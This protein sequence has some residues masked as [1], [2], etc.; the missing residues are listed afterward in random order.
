[1][2]VYEVRI[3]PLHFGKRKRGR[4]DPKTKFF[5]GSTLEEIDEFVPKTL[6]RKQATSKFA[7]I[8]DITGKLGPMLAEAEDWVTPMPDSLRSRWL[9]QFLLWEK[10]RG[11]RFQ[12][13][14]MPE[15]AADSKL[16]L[17]VKVDAANK[18]MVQGCWGGF[19]KKSGNWSCQHLLARV[20]L[21]GKNSTIPKLELQSL[22]NGSNM[23]WLL[24]K[25]L[26]DWVENYIV[27][28]D[29][30]IALCWVSSEKSSLSMFHRNRVIQIRRSSELE[31]M[32]HV[33]SNENLADLGTRPEKVKISDIGPDSEWECGKNWMCEDIKVSID[34]GILTPITKL[35]LS[36]EKDTDVFKEGLLSGD[37]DLFCN[38]V[39]E[40]RVEK[41]IQRFNFSQYLLNPTKYDFKKVVRIYALVISFI[42]KCKQKVSKK[43]V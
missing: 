15:D 13:A 9:S 43:I 40:T 11:M 32:Y 5:T 36:E 29:S 42:E 39:N 24:R 31:C 6:N 33:K 18:M 38:I 8:W 17:I 7:S 41:L 1:M 19:R 34:Q 12:R 27:C 3:P 23:C 16:R 28:S 37:S 10:L 2:D 4:L 22:T 20:I 35:R 30:N 26:D 14:V 21:S 25:M